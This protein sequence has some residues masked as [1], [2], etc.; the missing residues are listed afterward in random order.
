MRPPSVTVAIPAYNESD[1]I[2]ACLDAVMA[3]TYP[4][5]T[6]V[7]VIDGR[8]E[9]DTR[10]RAER[11]AGVRVLDN[12]LRIQAAA[13]NAAL[14]VA[15]GE[16][17]VR[18]DGHCRIAPDYVERAV[19]AL[20]RTGAALVGGAMTPIGTSWIQR[21]I[22]VAMI[23]RLGAGPARFHRRGGPGW[24][25]TVYLGAYRTQTG[26]D[27]GGYA[28]DLGVNEDA[29]FARRMTSRGGIYFDSTICSTYTPRATVRAVAQQ[30]F[31]YGK[32]RAATIRRH[33]DSL[34]A[35]QLAA[36]LL[37]IGLLSPVRNRVGLAYGFVVLGR[38]AWTARTDPTAGVAMTAVLPA[39]HLSWGLGFFKGLLSKS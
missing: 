3:Q 1:A 7:L 32:S 20:E 6:E 28:P 26:R 2:E 18:V 12:P 19:D 15:T 24:V 4:N 34:A 11:V 27:V 13:L 14:S 33:P 39:M 22:S 36:P 30:F 5:V 8:S 16:V 35:R 29:E 38:A 37:V 21:G 25:D 10:L 31:R 17:F 23:S 9:D